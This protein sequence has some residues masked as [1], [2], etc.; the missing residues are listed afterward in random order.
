MRS[1]GYVRQRAAR[2]PG[3]RRTGLVAVLVCEDGDRMFAD[4]YFSRILRGI[5]RAYPRPI[6]RSFC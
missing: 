5:N 4:P 3:P 1:L 6:T 2:V